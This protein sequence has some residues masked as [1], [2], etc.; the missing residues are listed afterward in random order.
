[1]TFFLTRVTLQAMVLRKAKI[2]DLEA[3]MDIY[4]VARQGMQR[5]GNKKQWGDSYPSRELIE[6]SILDDK[7]YVFQHKGELVGTFYFAVEEEATYARIY[8]GEWL[9]DDPYG[10]VHRL[11]SNGRHKGVAH[12]CLEWCLLQCDNMRIDT[13]RDNI[14]MQN[15]LEKNGYVRCGMIFTHDATERLAFQKSKRLY[16]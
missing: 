15:I 7:Q 5:S 6:K 11:A 12:F 14:I 9:N 8:N 4:H 13:H 10:V 3:I 16:H 1:M 2:K